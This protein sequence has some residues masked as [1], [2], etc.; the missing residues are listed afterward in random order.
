MVALDRVHVVE[1]EIQR[2]L[3]QEGRC[4][5][6]NGEA[7][8][9]NHHQNCKCFVNA[10]QNVTLFLSFANPSEQFPD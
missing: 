3:A 4:L 6:E 10:M 9:T 7:P 1:G 2:F 8:K 5:I